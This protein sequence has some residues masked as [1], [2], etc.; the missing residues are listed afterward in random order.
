MFSRAVWPLFAK[1][2]TTTVRRFFDLHEYQSKDLMRKYGVL[3]QRGD[4]ATTPQQA[5]TVAKE[6]NVTEGDLILKAQVHAGGRGKGT[7]SSGLK[8]GVQILKTPEQVQSFTEKMIGYNL[9]THQTPKDGLKVNAVLIHEGVDIVRQ[10]YLAFILDRN[11]QRPAIVA[12]T[13]GGME[14]EE[15]AKHNPDAVKLYVIEVDTGITDELLNKLEKDLNL[16]YVKGFREQV[17]NLYHL[18][19]ECDAVQLEI[20][21]WAVNPKNEIYSVDAKI[22]IDDNAKFR[23]KELFELKKNSL[24][25]EDVDPHEDKAIAAGLNYVALDGNIGCMVNGAGLAMATMDI[26]KLK[27]GEPANFLD[28]GGGANVE[29]VKIAFE[30]LSSHPKVK[31]ILINIFGGIMKCD[32]IANGI[33]KAAELVNLQLPLVCRLTG[34]NAD[35]ANELLHEFTKKNTHLKIEVATDL[36]DAAVKA[37]R[38]ASLQ[39]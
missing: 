34:T 17:R 26:I 16:S 8:G 25:S 27:G 12:S 2:L 9:V 32:T 22:G 30:I 38:T 21:P 36:D 20:N 3:V 10:I 37:V 39:K 29:Q 31:T 14:I 6:L 15:V 24:A 13:E 18:F 19:K 5:F 7:L 4:I 33:I 1:P 11:S 35:K 23:Q 28:V